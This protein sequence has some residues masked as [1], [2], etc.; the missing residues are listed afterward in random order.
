[1]LAPRVYLAFTLPLIGIYFAFPAGGT[2]QSVIYEL[3]GGTA[4]LAI[5]YAIR[6]HRPEH[7]LPWVLFAA[8]NALFVVGDVI[9]VFMT[10]PPVPSPADIFYL[11]GYPLIAAG[12]LLLMLLAGGLDRRGALTDAA[13]FTLGFAL[14]QWMFLMGPAVRGSGSRATHIVSGLYPAMDVVLLAGFA[15]FFVSPAWRTSAF[16]Y[17]VAA[18]VALFVGDEIYGLN[19]NAYA[20]GDWVDFTWMLS[21]VLWAA[22]A[23][24]PSMRELSRVRHMPAVRIARG[25]IAVL[26]AALVTVPVALLVQ[27]LR[28]KPLDVYV[29]VAIAS[30]ISLLV[31]G[32]LAGILRALERSH[33]SES[34]ARTVA[35]EA[36]AQLTVQNARLVEA[37]RLKDE[38][39]ALI[40][41][42]LRTPLTS[43][44]G[45]VELALDDAVDPPLDG[46]RRSYLEVVSRS[47]ERLLR[48]VDD[49]LFIARLQAGR[50]VLEPTQLDLCVLAAQSVEEARPR[51]EA[52]SV[53]ISSLVGSPVMIAVDK[54][55]IFQLLDNLISNAVKFTPEGGHIDVRVVPELDGA[56][57]EVSDNGIGL[58]PGEAELVFDRF[59]RSSRVAAQHT[60][61]TGLGL[62]I[63][64][65]ITEA[66]GGRISAASRE[67]GGTTFRIELPPRLPRAPEPSATEAE[68]VA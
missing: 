24:H 52:K 8:G 58:E 66:H 62:F 6:L 67:G 41:H 40:S 11:A 50:L 2:A 13:I 21:Y 34:A 16:R 30:A 15:G 54:G 27:Q 5:L 14:L 38:F 35:E 61:G 45:Y 26:A 64:R 32:R 9:A 4:V 57:I 7:R 51:A 39:V 60:P 36:H 55:R 12:L 49:L 68:L 22:A 29:V 46:E 31:V 56:V 33:G 17:L 25:R 65:A 59:F 47:S 18:V 63:A 42:D 53:S 10:D 19:S 44:V 1:L 43:I 23:L 37:D 48:L 3:L 20:S 28:G